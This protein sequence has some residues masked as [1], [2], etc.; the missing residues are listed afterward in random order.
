MRP[1][2]ALRSR[3][4]D[5]AFVFPAVLIFSIFYVYPFVQ[6]FHLSFFEWDGIV[7]FKEAIPVG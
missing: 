1:G 7:P 5:Y 6:I 2:S 3:L 4:E